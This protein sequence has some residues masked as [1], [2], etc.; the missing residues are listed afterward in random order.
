MSKAQQSAPQGDD[1]TASSLSLQEQVSAQAQSTIDQQ[2]QVPPDSTGTTSIMKTQFLPIAGE[3][4]LKIDSL[5]SN[6]RR[7]SCSQRNGFNE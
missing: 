3:P 7:S 4:P 6:V 1:A 5:V 2:V